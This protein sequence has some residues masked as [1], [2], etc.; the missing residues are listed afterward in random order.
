M[1]TT[2]RIWTRV[3]RADILAGNHWS[4]TG[5]EAERRVER[6]RADAERHRLPA[7]TSAAGAQ[8]LRQ[9]V[10]HGLVHLGSAIQGV[11]PTGC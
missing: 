2:Q 4:G 3:D 8:G 9:R 7:A 1:M 6:L 5:V 10:G 11:E